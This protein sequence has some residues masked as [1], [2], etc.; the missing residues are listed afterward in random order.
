MKR[1]AV[2]LALA[3]A[4]LT[5][6]THASDARVSIDDF[7]GTTRVR[8]NPH[9]MSCAWSEPCFLVGADWNSKRPDVAILVVEFM[10]AYTPIKAAALNIDGE[11]VPLSPPHQLTDYGQGIVFTPGTY[12]PALAQA[13]RTSTQGFDVP[14]AV[15]QR[16]LAARTVKMRI[17]VAQGNIDARL[18][19]SDKTSKA[20]GALQRFWA[21]VPHSTALVA[22]AEPGT[23]ESNAP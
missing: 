16:V 2:A 3:A 15:L 12:N 9:G 11:V 21:K 6:V 5:G 13:G 18:I 1:I 4:V 22:P 20:Y 14:L 23:A 17:I 7:D 19:D 10:G 8:V